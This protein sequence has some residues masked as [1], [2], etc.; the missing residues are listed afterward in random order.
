M[1]TLKDIISDIRVFLYGGMITLPLTLAGTMLILGLFTAN[2]AILFFLVGY[3]ILAP[4]GAWSLNKITDVICTFAESSR[5]LKKS[6]DICKIIVPYADKIAPSIQQVEERFICS[7][8]L[9]MIS[10]FI[11]YMMMNAYQLMSKDSLNQ[12]LVINKTEVA[13]AAKVTNRK[14]QAMIAFASIIIFGLIAIGIRYYSGCE[15]WYSTILGAS[16][17]GIGYLWY[18]MLS[19][20]GQD[21]LSDLF[22]IANR[23]MAPSAILNKPIACVPIPK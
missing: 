7:E 18:T 10:F 16:F 3:L 14:T 20:V 21:R 15:T 17:G 8:W 23:L 9:A 5:F 13:D 6:S 12:P 19:Q 4:V 1:D 2:Y 11:G 22:G